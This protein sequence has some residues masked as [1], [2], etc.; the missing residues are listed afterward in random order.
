MI[1]K[2]DDF[3]KRLMATFEIE[4]KEHI[5]AISSRLIELEKAGAAE[6][7]KE[8]IEVIFR[9]AHSLKGAAR[10]VNFT[11]I[12]SICHSLESVF[13]AL[14]GKDITVSPGMFDML[15]RAGD[16]LG[17]LL[18][19]I[20]SERT[21][22]ERS[23]T[24]ELI[25]C[26]DNAVKGQ[27]IE[28]KG[29]G[30]EFRQKTEPI[31]DAEPPQS[32]IQHP[33]PEPRPL[34]HVTAETVRIS[35]AKL[36]SILLQAEELLSAKLSASQRAAELRE[37]KNLFLEWKK[38]LKS[39][40]GQG[41]L[42]ENVE[43]GTVRDGITNPRN[44]VP[45]TFL[46]SLE[47]KLTML[48]KSV[49]QDHYFLGRMVD[50]L[51]Q[52]MKK[53]LMLPF[54]SLLEIIPKLVRDLSRD[55][56]KDVNLEIRGG[57]VEIDKRILDE[58]KD[59]MI[60]LVRNCLDHGIER[61]EER[62][63]KEKPVEGTITITI[64]A[65]NSSHVEIVISDDGAGII[66][67]KVRAAALKLGIISQEEAERLNEPEIRSLIYH[68]GVSTS[69]IATDISGRG[70]GLAIVSE[71]VEK[72]GGGILIETQPDVG[73]MFRIV[74]PLTLAT[75]RGILAR[76]DEHLFIFPT[77]SVE[78]VIRVNKEEIKT[79]ENRETIQIN[80][81]AA[82]LVRLE[83]VLE[84]A[85]SSSSSH[86]SGI[87]QVVVI[88][89]LEKRIG[90]LVDEVLNEQEV[91]VKNLG[92]Q[93]PHV[94]NI[95]GATVLGTG[96]VVPILNVSD[97]IK[98]AV[99]VATAPGRTTA[100]AEEVK[101]K[102]KSILV[103][104]DSITARTLLKNILESAG[105]DVRTAVDGVD[106]FTS[107]RTED[108]DLVVSDIDMPRM[109]GFDLAAKIRADKKLSELPVVLVTALESREDRER[110]IEVGA[111]AYIVKSSFDQSNLLEVIKRLI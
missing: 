7:Q 13:S 103:V 77:T 88:A 6:K 33:A 30:S 89:S 9:E 40:R 29:Q 50:G 100:A 20:G 84:L 19:S 43:I 18:L 66:V 61:P 58:M 21:V 23:G 96:K 69:P 41:S 105:Y 51:L 74:L 25:Q 93:L 70:L 109:N 59:P 95:T 60:H 76:V 48:A 53:V 73:T 42:V 22:S 64:S 5:N 63:R 12:E 8:I 82:A 49:D 4:A 52:D 99:K 62:A 44:H 24:A 31:P 34:A 11:E 98:S 3:L 79:V 36:E 110:G 26:L 46:A 75:F 38:T 17:K 91:L 78:R 28:I 27:G 94:R 87:A 106:A 101:A 90:F 83:H 85:P 80:G 71:K 65:K 1:K 102:K 54:S 67:A 107:L 92:K 32:D 68:S 45:E 104:E 39:F 35:T 14:K 10:A 86:S 57:E 15:H 81:Q 97:L 16:T 55:Q 56:G 72:L 37:M 111:N 108:F 47:N 2:D